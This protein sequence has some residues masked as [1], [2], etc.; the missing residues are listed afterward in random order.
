MNECMKEECVFCMAD[1]THR[2]LQ[3]SA[4]PRRATE[5]NC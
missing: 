3:Q 1:T 2:L 4:F 5:R